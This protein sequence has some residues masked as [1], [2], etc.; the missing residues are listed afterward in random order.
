MIAWNKKIIL[1]A[2]M[3][4]ASGLAEA[5]R[6]THK[7]AD[8]GPKVELAAMVP[9]NFGDW[10]NVPQTAGEIVNPEQ[11]ELVNRI[12]ND[13]L[14]RS[15]VRNDGAMVMLSIA[16]GANQSDGV[17]LH[18]PE[19]CY[20]AQGFALISM[21]QGALPTAYGAIPVKRLLTKL[22]N[23]SEPLTYWSTLGTKVV[24]GGL[25]TKLT[26]LNYGFRG[27]IPD[28]LLFRVS[29]ISADE[30]AGYALQQDFVRDLV[31]AM[32]PRDRL[33][34]AGLSAAAHGQ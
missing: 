1:L 6:P 2:G 32:S 10:K 31:A 17:A 26:Q 5:L 11:K 34:M 27:Q 21:Q 20:P 14:S 8:E 12:Y 19:I 30:Q 13:T 3:L 16:Y 25:Q 33:K 29:S 7:I 22:G 28:G 9:L 24:L 23:R 4:L 15:Y 18:Y